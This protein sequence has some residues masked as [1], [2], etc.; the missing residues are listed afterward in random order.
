M[1]ATWILPPCL[2]KTAASLYNLIDHIE[3]DNTIYCVSALMD[4]NTEQKHVVIRIKSS[5]MK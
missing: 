5:K 3:T 2:L 1:S 4:L